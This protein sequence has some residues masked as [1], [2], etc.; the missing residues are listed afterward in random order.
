[1]NER[2]ARCMLLAKVLNADG[3]I[4]DEESEFLEVAME[5]FGLDPFERDQVRSLEGWDEAE[6]I[7]ATLA[8]EEKRAM[9]DSLVAAVLVDGK[10]S[11]SEMETIEKLSTALGLR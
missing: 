10:V 4:I 7:V 3:Q 1:M 6:P 2:L 8:Q 5:A 11:S 9:M